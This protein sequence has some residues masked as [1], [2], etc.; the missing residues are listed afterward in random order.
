M[1]ASGFAFPLV[2][3]CALLHG[4]VRAQVPEA[5]VRVCATLIFAQERQSPDG[6]FLSARTAAASLSGRTVLTPHFAVHYTVAPNLHRVRW[7][8]EDAGLRAAVDSVL[9]ALPE[10][11]SGYQRDSALHAELD[12]AD[13]PHPLYARRAAAYF[14]RAWVYYDSLGMRM[15]GYASTS[16]V[17]TAS[18]QGRY[19]VDIADMNAGAGTRG[20][21]Y[22]VAYSPSRGGSVVIENDFLYDAAYT[23]GTDTVTGSPLQV[24][25]AGQLRNYHTEWDMG[26]KVTAVHELYHSV[27]FA[28]TPSLP[29]PRHAWYE[30]SAV[31]MEE[32][33][34]PEV[35]D[36][37]Q[38]LP[39]VVPHNHT[40]NPLAPFNGAAQGY[41][42]G[43]FHMFLSHARGTDFDKH[44][45][46]RLDENGN[47]LPDAL[48]HMAGSQAAW[49]SLF[50]AYAA[51]M[52]LAGAPAAVESP[53]AY[54]PDM[55]QWPRPRFDTV[56]AA[57]ISELNVP[58]GTFRIVHP[59]AAGGAWA[60]LPGFSG[61]WRIDSAGM[62]ALFLAGEAVHLQGPGAP[63]LAAG[64]S[65]FAGGAARVLSLAPIASGLAAHPNPASRM[66]QTIRFSAPE[67]DFTDSL[68][69]ITESGRR[70]ATLAPDSAGAGAG[71]GSYWR[72]DL[73]DPEN[74]TVSPGIYLYRAPGLDTRPL[75]I[76]R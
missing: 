12:A 40:V 13:A 36:Y 38:F 14:E 27:H 3:S 4:I 67:T 33:L 47:N 42:S 72:W 52:S 48:V 73:K 8:P 44:V 9:A 53:L 23:S 71:F 37:F 60:A 70:V 32:R 16:T 63:V 75:L 17:F 26:L 1:H 58:P 18:G 65:A 30:I 7:T 68:I 57:A 39:F 5:P 46:E 10:G 34:A 43:I 64:N 20:P 35:N 69:I 59:P 55:A 41:G 22:G 51:A 29:S 62:N 66:E 24:H 49:D 6:S 61:A 28:Y 11:L 21:N 74:R 50:N 15:P 54:T 19:V 56:N 76:L 25:L 45:W 2:V 31:G